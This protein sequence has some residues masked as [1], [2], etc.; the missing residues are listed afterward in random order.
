[1]WERLPPDCG[2]SPVQTDLWITQHQA[3]AEPV[4]Q[5][6]QQRARGVDLSMAGLLDYT[7]VKHVML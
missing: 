6:E 7:Q 5:G 2:L 1:M 4:A 3:D